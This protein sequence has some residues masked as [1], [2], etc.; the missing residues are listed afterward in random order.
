MHQRIT[1]PDHRLF[2][3]VS[4]WARRITAHLPESLPQ[5]VQ[6]L[7]THL[8][9][10]RELRPD[11]HHA[12]AYDL[13]GSHVLGDAICRVRDAAQSDRRAL[14]VP[15][16]SVVDRFGSNGGGI[17]DGKDRDVLRRT[18]SAWCPTRPSA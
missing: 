6:C 16:R 12:P 9:A 14:P 5:Q 18:L 2:P 15:W 3:Y 17:L 7:N 4:I 8:L 10:G 1:P 13:A 11:G